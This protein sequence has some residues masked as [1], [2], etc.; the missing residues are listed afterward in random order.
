LTK[1]VED[2]P[3]EGGRLIGTGT[4]EQPPTEAAWDL[5]ICHASE[6]KEE[7]ARPL[8]VSLRN[9]G[10]RV[11]YDEFTLTLG[12]SLSRSIDYGLA[13]SRFGIV[14]LSPSFFKKAWPRRELD[15]LTAKEVRYGKTILPIWHNV[16]RDLVLK[17]SPVLADKFAVLTSE[18]PDRVVDEILKAV[19]KDKSFE[20]RLKEEAVPLKR[21]P[22]TAAAVA[23][24]KRYLA[25]SR[26][27]PLHDLIHG[28]TE[29]VYQELASDR[30]VCGGASITK[31]MFQE[32]MRQYEALVERLMAM[33]A[34]LSYYDDDNSD[35]LTYCID[36]LSEQPRRDGLVILLDL[37]LYPALLVVYAGGISALA[38][39]RFRNLAAIMRNTRCR[40]N[41]GRK[42]PA[43]RQ[44]NVDSV[45][46]RSSK[47]V[48]R[49]NAEREYTPA[50]NYLFDLLRPVLHDYLPSETKYEE[51]Y[52][53]FEYLS[54]L[55]YVDT[56]DTRWPP[57]GRFGWRV[58][59]DG[60]EN[61]ALY[62]F[63]S[64]GIG[65]GTDWR[66]LKAGFFNGSIERFKEVVQSHQH[67]LHEQTVGW[68]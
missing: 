67:R 37:Q 65:Q 16:D 55:T 59:E 64:N 35:N 30:F 48:S 50:S 44:V 22:S 56:V 41:S 3:G 11:W 38:A 19:E 25:E 34:A 23:I 42:R 33:L 51:T 9:K 1:P 31:D 28:E 49:P 45:F 6:D 12:D 2:T 58:K 27:I 54:A 36:R 46:D 29:T 40:D 26:R 32:R 47:W 57:V 61:S 24:V 14:V 68:I 18:G 63:V 5:F 10:L 15:G 43:L 21:S 60:W 62:E 52:D 17:Y 4:G 66:L 7:I 53:L 39:E 13:N 20:G 8:A